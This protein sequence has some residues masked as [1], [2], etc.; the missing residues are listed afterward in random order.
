MGKK[1]VVTLAALLG[2]GGCMQYLVQPPQPSLAGA[3]HEIEAQSYLGSEIQ[4]PPYV[5]AK[6]CLGREQLG[7]VLV[8]RNFGQGLLSWLTLGLVAPATIMYQCA[9][10][11]QPP[12]VTGGDR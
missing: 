4:S 7:R 2:T 5:L 10:A 1:H 8:K 3:E 9:N 12:L 6:K 11:R